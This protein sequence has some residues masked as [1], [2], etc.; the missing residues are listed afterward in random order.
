MTNNNYEKILDTFLSKDVST[1]DIE[2][3]GKI[4]HDVISLIGSLSIIDKN[5]IDPML[6]ISLIQL[7]EIIDKKID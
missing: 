6:Q 2:I 7:R 3:S 1:N 5:K 4:S